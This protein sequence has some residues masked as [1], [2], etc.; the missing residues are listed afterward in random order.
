MGSHIKGN[1]YRRK[2]IVSRTLHIAAVCTLLF[3]GPGLTI[4][5]NSYMGAHPT[6]WNCK[7]RH[8]YLT[9]V[10]GQA[11]V[12]CGTV[13]R[14]SGSDATRYMPGLLPPMRSQ[15]Y[16][17]LS[18]ENPPV[19]VTSPVSRHS[20]PDE[21]VPWPVVR[22]GCDLRHRQST[23][24]AGSEAHPIQSQAMCCLLPAMWPSSNP[25]CLV[26]G[27]RTSALPERAVGGSPIYKARMSPNTPRQWPPPFPDDVSAPLFAR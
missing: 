18:T 3:F 9:A 21:L 13:L 8:M 20:S 10:R 2:V 11:P 4:G 22:G 1:P 7:S 6:S 17:G 24:G 23:T 19:P 26:I 12:R 25:R 16:V 27:S 15:S 14:T 5:F